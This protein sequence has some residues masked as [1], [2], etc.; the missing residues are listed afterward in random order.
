M[1]DARRK[2]AEAQKRY[3]VQGDAEDREYMRRRDAAA[4]VGRARPSGNWRFEQLLNTSRQLIGW[5][6]ELDGRIAGMMVL[7]GEDIQ[8]IS[9]SSDHDASAPNGMEIMAAFVKLYP[10]PRARQ[11]PPPSAAHQLPGFGPPRDW[12]QED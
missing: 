12:S 6:V 11:L 4:G 5:R 9:T 3:D 8:V 1:R 2:A 7:Q 10:D